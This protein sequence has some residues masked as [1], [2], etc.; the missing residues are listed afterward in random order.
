MN[1]LNIKVL[2]TIRFHLIAKVSELSSSF[3]PILFSETKVVPWLSLV[4]RRLSIVLWCI[5]NRFH[6]KISDYNETCVGVCYLLDNIRLWSKPHK[7]YVWSD[8]KSG[9]KRKKKHFLK[10]WMSDAKYNFWEGVFI[11]SSTIVKYKIK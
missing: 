8:I 2:L 4:R 10:N 1:T 3:Y 5:V 9:I 7:C 6:Y 11:W